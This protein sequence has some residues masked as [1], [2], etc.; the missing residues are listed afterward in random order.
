MSIDPLFLSMCLS[1]L[2]IGLHLTHLIRQVYRT[3]NPLSIFFAAFCIGLHL[4]L[5]IYLTD[6]PLLKEN[7]IVRSLIHISTLGICHVMTSRYINQY[8]GL[9][10]Y[11]YP[12]RL[13]TLVSDCLIS[14][15][16]EEYLC[17]HA[18]KNDLMNHGPS[19]GQSYGLSFGLSFGLS[20]GSVMHITSILFG[21]GHLSNYFENM[22]S[23]VEHRILFIKVVL[24]IIHTT[25][26]G[27]ILFSS[28]TLLHCILFHSYY[29]ALTTILGKIYTMMMMRWYDE[30]EIE[31]ETMNLL[32]P[33]RRHSF[34]GESYYGYQSIRVSKGL[35]DQHNDSMHGLTFRK[36][37]YDQCQYQDYE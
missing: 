25:V 37:Q 20:Q 26:L 27:Y 10:E 28:S 17:R 11:D 14:P 31:N 4:I 22:Y 19:Y 24:Q 15:L 18:I 16:I 32:V 12:I 29:N 36:E 9:R 21:L 6:N 23:L 3:A 7:Q 1:T 13:G 8:H 5:L 33:R 30:N 34:Q 35:Y 2:C